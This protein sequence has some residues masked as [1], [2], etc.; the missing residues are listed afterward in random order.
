MINPNDYIINGKVMPN[1][2]AIDIKNGII[3]RSDIQSLIA[4]ERIKET[5]NDAPVTKKDKALWDEQYLNQLTYSAIAGSFNEEYLYYLSDVAEHVNK[6]RK[7]NS[8]NKTYAVGLS[9]IAIIVVIIIVIKIIN[10][11]S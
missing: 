8:K 3:S 5:F 7:N 4:D 6:P 10:A 2:I 1:R 11:A 9:V